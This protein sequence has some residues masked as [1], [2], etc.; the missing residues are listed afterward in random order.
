MGWQD[1]HEVQQRGVQS[2]L[3]TKWNPQAPIYLG[4]RGVTSWKAALQKMTWGS[5]W[6]LRWT[7]ARN[8]KLTGAADVKLSKKAGWAITAET[9][10]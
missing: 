2:H 10:N 1:P 3:G 8:R 6:T 7:W 4:G 5:W 9:G